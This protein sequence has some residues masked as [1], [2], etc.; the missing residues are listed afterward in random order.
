MFETMQVYLIVFIVLWDDNVP[1]HN[2]HPDALRWS[3]L[4]NFS[5]SLLTL[6]SE[7]TELKRRASLNRE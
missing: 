5:E 3:F 4:F 2:F 6:S 1:I 7:I